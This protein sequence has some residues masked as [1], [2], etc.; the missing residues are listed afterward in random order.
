MRKDKPFAVPRQLVWEAYRRV[1]AK[2][3]AAGVDG[4]AVEQF[5]ADLEGNLYKIGNRL[6]SGSY[7]PP[8]LRAV[9]IPKPHG[10]GTRALGVPTIADRTAQTV[11]AMYLEPLV[12][13]RFHS[14]SWLSAGEG[15]PRRGRGMPAAVPGGT[16]GSS[17]LTSRSSSTPF[18]GT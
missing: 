1:A 17:I 5:E 10:P 12:E 4:Q 16:T 7:F 9:E 6:S 13:P 14:D 8:P 11:V 18:P 15:G 2:K 3:G